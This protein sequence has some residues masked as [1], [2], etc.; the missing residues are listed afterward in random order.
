MDVDECLS[1]VTPN[2]ARDLGMLDEPSLE[3]VFIMVHSCLYTVV[4]SF[5]LAFSTFAILA[6]D[7]LPRESSPQW[8]L[9]SPSLLLKLVLTDSTSL[10][11]EEF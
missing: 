5:A 11:R 7:L 9:I 8:R 4:H 6:A 10:Y 2:T 3:R 1:V